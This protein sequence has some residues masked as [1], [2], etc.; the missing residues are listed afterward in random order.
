MAH[1]NKLGSARVLL[2]SH[3]LTDFYDAARAFPGG[4]N[5]RAWL[6]ERLGTILGRPAAV[7][8]RLTAAPGQAHHEQAHHEQARYEAGI[9]TASSQAGAPV[10][11]AGRRG[12]P[13]SLRTVAF[14]ALP[15]LDVDIP[16]TVEFDLAPLAAAIGAQPNPI[17]SGVG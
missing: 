5:R 13:P 6:S 9:E 1:Q 2:R 17:G 3:G 14:P 7:G 10:P 12:R 11:G 4:P 16:L 8:L 15:L